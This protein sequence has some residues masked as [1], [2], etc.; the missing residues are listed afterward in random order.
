MSYCKDC[1]NFELCANGYGEVT[2]DTEITNI[3]GKPCHYFKDRT[4]FVELPC[5]VGDKVYL[6]ATRTTKQSRKKVVINYIE[7]GIVDNITLGQIMIPQI[8]V[9]ITNN[10]WITFDS[11][12]DIGKAVFLTR[13][14]AE[15]ALKERE[16]K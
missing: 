3:K 1:F 16:Q 7:T 4:K 14:E 13:E 10:V 15:K 9:C 8:D 12:K 11:E 6:L 2:A 5:K